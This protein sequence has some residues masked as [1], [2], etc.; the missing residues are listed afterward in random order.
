MTLPLKIILINGFQEIFIGSKYKFKNEGD[1]YQMTILGP[2]V[3]DTGKYTIE[4]AGVSSSAYLNV[5]GV[6]YYSIVKSFFFLFLNVLY[7]IL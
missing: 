1:V 3:E 4:I 5:E 6:L 2:K 7:M